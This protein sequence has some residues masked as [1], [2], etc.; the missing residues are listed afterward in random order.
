MPF[1]QYSPEDAQSDNLLGS[2]RLDGGPFKI[3]EFVA[4]PDLMSRRVIVGHSPQ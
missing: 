4:H 2:K 3:A 1:S